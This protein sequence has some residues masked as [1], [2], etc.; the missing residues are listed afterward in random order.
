M[1]FGATYSIE[2]I[3]WEGFTKENVDTE[4]GIGKR[5]KLFSHQIDDRRE[6]VAIGTTS[7]QDWC[8]K[9]VYRFKL[10]VSQKF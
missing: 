1:Q 10:K 5:R 8:K 6:L 4:V 3:F 9:T 7:S 2:T